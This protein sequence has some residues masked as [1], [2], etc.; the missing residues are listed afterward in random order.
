M[1]GRRLSIAISVAATTALFGACG[2]DSGSD[3]SGGGTSS[4]V[5]GADVVAGTTA[6]VAIVNPVVNDANAAAVPAELGTE[7]ASIAVDA[8]PGEDDVTDATG[9]ALVEVPTGPIDLS[10]GDA[11]A[12][13]H[14]VLAAGDVYDAA[15]A[16]D[17]AA[18]AFFP[19]TPIRYAVGSESGAFFFDPDDAIDDIQAR[20]GEDDVV[21]VLRPGTYT[22]SLDIRGRGAVLFG[23]GWSDRAVV[24]DGSV[25]AN[26][27]QV[28]LRGLT[29]TGD[30][31]SN[32]NGFGISFSVVR[33]GADIKG[34]GGAFLRNVFCGSAT[35]PSSSATLLDNVGIAPS[36]TLPT[37][38]D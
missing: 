10:V 29:I 31:T 38:C 24:I 18:A 20:L 22:G 30:L 12:L 1:F 33:G 27:E 25:I 36:L 37:E 13:P 3:G 2:D 32:G 14:S 7:R 11:P 5:G 26:G 28:R 21:V 17:G 15:V 19:N 35:V 9:L 8:E 16:Y 6:I 23:E 34:N 4:G